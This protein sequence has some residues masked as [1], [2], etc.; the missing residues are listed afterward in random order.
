VIA[1]T[2]KSQPY[3]IIIHL[4]QGVHYKLLYRI[5]LHVRKEVCK[6][7]WHQVAFSIQATE[8]FKGKRKINIGGL[9]DNKCQI[10]FSTTSTGNNEDVYYCIEDGS[11]PKCIVNLSWF[12]ANMCLKEQEHLFCREAAAVKHREKLFAG[13]M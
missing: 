9:V 10:I 8:K 7:G 13:K 11:D 2:S 1:S 6:M 4:Q 5:Y 3:I 12:M